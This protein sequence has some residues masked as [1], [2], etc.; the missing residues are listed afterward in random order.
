MTETQWR[1]CR[2]ALPMLNYPRTWG[3]KRRQQLFACACVRRVL[4]LV[5]GDGFAEAVE[6][7]ENHA[8]GAASTAALHQADVRLRKDGV[9]LPRYEARWHARSAV[10]FLAPFSAQKNVRVE[11]EVVRAVM[12]AVAHGPVWASAPISRRLEVC[13]ALRAGEAAQLADLVRD[14][15]PFRPVPSDPAWLTPAVV[16]L[17][18]AAYDERRMPSGEMDKGRLW[19]LSD[20]LEEAGAESAVLDHLRG[21]GPHWRGCRVVDAL[22]GRS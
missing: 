15:F 17:A 6:V 14:L 10:A 11:V 16:S 4:H 18:H 3:G 21:P 2:S 7:V 20:A 5:D 9:L 8:D 13:T 1:D 19:V 22:M 12:E